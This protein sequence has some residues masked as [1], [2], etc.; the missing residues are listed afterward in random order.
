MLQ[1]MFQKISSRISRALCA[2]SFKEDSVWRIIKKFSQYSSFL[3]T[4]LEWIL[5]LKHKLQPFKRS[6]RKKMFQSTVNYDEVVTIVTNIERIMNCRPLTYIYNDNKEEVV[7][8]M[9]RSHQIFSSRFKLFWLPLDVTMC[10]YLKT[11]IVS[12]HI[13]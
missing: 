10:A 11:W 8:H 4:C 6:L 2:L 7:T 1:N 9:L 5:D 3:T 12:N 13:C